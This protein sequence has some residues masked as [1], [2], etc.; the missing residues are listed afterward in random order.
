MPESPLDLAA[1]LSALNQNDVRYIIIGGLAMV[2]HGSGHVTQDVDVFYARDAENR[3][4][5]V[6]AMAPHSPRLRGVPADLPFVWDRRT[7]RDSVNLTL[8]TALG[9]I[10]LLSEV[11]GVD[12]E[13]V[14]DR[15]VVTNL[16]GLTVHVAS[17]DDLIV[18]KRAAN[19][20][21]DQI[22]LMELEAL[23][24]LEDA[25]E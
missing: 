10:D 23:Q 12:F 13:A 3:L 11:P 6:R 4:A 20:P 5:L 2:S 24:A 7:L 8:D 16:F 25:Q 21:K 22:H 9:P 14:W 17:L 15:S 1:V 18:M 19:R